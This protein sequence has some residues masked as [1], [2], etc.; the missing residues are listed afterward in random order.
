M[1]A[2]SQYGMN[3]DPQIQ[4]LTARP[5]LQVLHQQMG[6]NKGGPTMFY[7]H[8]SLNIL[9]CRAARINNNSLWIPCEEMAPL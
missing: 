1:M 5:M 8:T 6:V 7:R 4:V 9:H 3:H 2:P